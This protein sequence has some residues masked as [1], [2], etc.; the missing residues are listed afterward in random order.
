[1]NIKQTLKRELQQRIHWYL[2]VS[3]RNSFG[4]KDLKSKEPNIRARLEKEDLNNIN[5][6][7]HNKLA[8]GGIN[9][10]NYIKHCGPIRT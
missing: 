3:P 6:L 5:L 9:G 7:W 8:G 4:K 10:L 2:Y 1:M